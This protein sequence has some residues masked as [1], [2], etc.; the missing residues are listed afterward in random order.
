MLGYIVRTSTD[1]S[2][3]LRLLLGKLWVST[4]SVQVVTNTS[5]SKSTKRGNS[6]ARHDDDVMRDVEFELGGVEIDAGGYA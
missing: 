5:G 4:G 6:T 1:V 3:T 2:L